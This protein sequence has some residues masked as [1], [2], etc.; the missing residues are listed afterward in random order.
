MRA[1]VCLA[2]WLFLVFMGPD[3]SALYFALGGVAATLK[4][5]YVNA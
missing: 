2:I 3:S 5:K 1:L 4:F